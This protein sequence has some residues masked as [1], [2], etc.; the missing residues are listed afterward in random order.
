MVRLRLKW[1]WDIGKGAFMFQS[2]YGAIATTHT[3][4]QSAHS[5]RRF[6]PTMVRLRRNT[7][8]QRTRPSLMFQS[9]YGA[10]ATFPFLKPI[11][12]PCCFNPTMVRLRRLARRPRNGVSRCFNPTMVRLRQ[13]WEEALETLKG[14]VS[15]PLWCDCDYASMPLSPRKIQVSIPLWCDCDPVR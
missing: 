2:H 12:L 13:A 15:I 5:D 3:V 8:H 4:H 1:L 11:L 14:L 6:N 7:M 9:H 10:I